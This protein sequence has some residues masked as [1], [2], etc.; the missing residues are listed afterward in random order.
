MRYVLVTERYPSFSFQAALSQ[1][2]NLLFVAYLDKIHV[3]KPRFPSQA[4]SEKPEIIIDLP[5][6]RLGLQG[7][8]NPISG[9][10]VNHLIVGD[11]GNEEIIVVACDDGDVISYKTRAIGLVLEQDLPLPEPW[12]L[13]NVGASAWGLA[14]HK[15]ARL[16]A[17]SSNTQVIEIFAPALKPVSH[18]DDM[19]EES[20]VTLPWKSTDSPSPP[21]QF[22]WFQQWMHV[23]G[24]LL[25]N[26]SLS[27]L[28]VSLAAHDNN[29]PNISFCNTDI[30]P[31]GRYLASTDINNNT[32][33]WDIY[34][35]ETIFRYHEKRSL[36]KYVLRFNV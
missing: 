32:F 11:L 7:Y 28:K 21:S 33:V 3:F 30:D 23:P 6:S 15:E 14:I 29:V 36:G 34:R 25:G 8:M 17:V 5:K 18:L 1:Y 20:S 19:I 24:T 9:H 4:L 12:F 16:L 2:Q 26:R 27:N 13:Q 10:Q 31:M 35:G 22:L